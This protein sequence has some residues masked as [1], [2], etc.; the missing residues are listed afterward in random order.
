[1]AIINSRS[2]LTSP[3]LASFRASKS[4]VFFR[5]FPSLSR[6]P[7]PP[8]LVGHMRVF[9]H[10]FPDLLGLNVESTSS[11]RNSVLVYEATVTI[12]LD[13]LIRGSVSKSIKLLVCIQENLHLISD[14]NAA[15]VGEFLG[16]IK[17]MFLG[18]AE[19]IMNVVPNEELSL[20]LLK[21]PSAKNLR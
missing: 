13:P 10:C 12:D 8:E 15:Y 7:T 5:F 18:R 17:K 20:S 11:R 14:I 2:F 1:M 3:P 6:A 9:S 21:K 19:S 4:T 16:T